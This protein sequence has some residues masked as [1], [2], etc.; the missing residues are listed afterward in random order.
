MSVLLALRFSSSSFSTFSNGSPIYFNISYFSQ[1]MAPQIKI[2]FLLKIIRTSVLH[3]CY[4]RQQ[5]NSSGHSVQE[6][7]KGFIAVI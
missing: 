1:L 4:N 3:N 5:F 2:I 6:L 7:I